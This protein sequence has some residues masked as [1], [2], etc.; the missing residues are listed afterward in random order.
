M[1]RTARRAQAQSFD[2][3]ARDYDRLAELNGSGLIGPRVASLLPARDR[4]AHGRALDLGCGA[5]RHAVLLAQRFAHVDAVDLSGPMLEVAQTHRP[6]PNISYRQADLLDVDDVGQYRFVLSA[7]TLHHVPDLHAAL[8]HI[9]TLLAPRGRLVVIDMYSVDAASASQR[10]QRAFER[11]VPLRLRL[12]GLFLLKLGMNIVRRGTAVA[13]EI[14]RL[15]TRRAWLDHRVSDRFFSRRELERS[16][17]A[18]FPGH[19]LEV[20]GGPRG[21]VLR[22]DA[23]G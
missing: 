20:L 7:L 22:W 21:V 18:L 10:L 15:S 9:K 17:Q 13:W 4:A 16:C 12:H 23:P 6:R 8:S 19:Q 11:T 1:R 14:Y 2:Q 3:V 5:G